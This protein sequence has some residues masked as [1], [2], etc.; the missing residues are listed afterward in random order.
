MTLQIRE[1]LISN[2]DSFDY[3]QSV[4][5]YPDGDK[6]FRDDLFIDFDC[7]VC[8]VSLANRTTF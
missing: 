7:D 5:I 6:R 4:S 2:G 8:A 3:R 1:N